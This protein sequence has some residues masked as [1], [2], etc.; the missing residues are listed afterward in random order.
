MIEY[1]LALITGYVMAKWFT[2][3]APKLQTNKYHIHHWMWGTALL[4]LLLILDMKDDVSVGLL[5]GIIL[6]GLSYKNW[7]I[8]RVYG[9]VR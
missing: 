1:S 8:Q 2:P 4:C 9:S 5:T 6:E 3:Y 7:K